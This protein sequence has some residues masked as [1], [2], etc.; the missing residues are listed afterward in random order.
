MKNLTS[1]RKWLVL[2]TA[3]VLLI[4][5]GMLRG[6]DVLTMVYAGVSPQS[7]FAH[8]DGDDDDDDDDNDDNNRGF[9]KKFVG[10]YLIRGV[11]PLVPGIPDSQRLRVVTLTK[12]GNFF[13]TSQQLVFLGFDDDKGTWKKTGHNEITTVSIQMAYDSNTLELIGAT[14][15]V[16]VL[17]FADKENGRFQTVTGGTVSGERFALGQNPLELT[18]TPISM[19]SVGISEGQRVVE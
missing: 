15:V 9:A 18:E 4:A 5:L 13:S 8:N 6:S 19:F 11:E 14:R 3:G 1:L 2:G 10:T 16:Y 7:V 17:T 12:D